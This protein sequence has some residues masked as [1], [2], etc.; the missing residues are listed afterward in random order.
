MNAMLKF[1][2]WIWLMKWLGWMERM[3]CVSLGVCMCEFKVYSLGLIPYQNTTTG[4]FLIF[5]KITKI[6][7]L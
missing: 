3:A 4:D 7:N 2:E 6:I 5:I 1:D